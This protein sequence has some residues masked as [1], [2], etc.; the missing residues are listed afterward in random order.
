MEEDKNHVSRDRVSGKKIGKKTFVLKDF[1]DKVA[2]ATNA[3][4]VFNIFHQQYE[5]YQMCQ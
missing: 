2:A 4:H 3:N 1:I 5:I